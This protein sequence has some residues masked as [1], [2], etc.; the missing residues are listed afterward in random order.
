MGYFAYFIWAGSLIFF[1]YQGYSAATT[2][3]YMS[4]DESSG[5]CD[6]VPNEISGTFLADQLGMWESNS[7]FQ[8][9]QATYELNLKGL[10]ISESQYDAMMNNIK[11]AIN[12]V[13][14]DAPMRDLFQNLL[15][16]TTW[17]YPI[18]N[19]V[20]VFY[21][22]AD[23]S[24]IFTKRYHYA[25]IASSLGTCSVRPSTVYDINSATFTLS[26]DYDNYMSA[27]CDTLINPE[28]MGY[29][30]EA[31]DDFVIPIDM[32]SFMIAAAVRLLLYITY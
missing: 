22:T 24:T 27:S 16:W 14:R 25:A 5:S 17:E 9:S 13:A 12:E 29:N 2:Q 23:V 26:F 32:H 15:Y 6:S 30:A 28:Q 21:F 8:E 1:L 31:D 11:D 7:N 10:S 4:L 19:T 3:A 20:S 18:P